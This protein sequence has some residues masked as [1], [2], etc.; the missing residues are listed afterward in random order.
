M[1]HFFPLA[2]TY[3]S[4]LYNINDE[5]YFSFFTT[6]NSEKFMNIYEIK[7]LNEEIFFNAE[8]VVKGK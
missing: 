1:D 8:L 5:N 7:E 6:Y 3:P 4:Y 2:S